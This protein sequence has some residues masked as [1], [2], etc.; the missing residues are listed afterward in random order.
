M[1][2]KVTRAQELLDRIAASVNMSEA[3]KNWLVATLD[4]MHDGPILCTG[5]PDN[6]DSPSVLQVIKQTYPV[7]KPNFNTGGAPDSDTWGFHARLDDYLIPD[8]AY[9]QRANRPGEISHPWQQ[10]EGDLLLQDLASVSVNSQER[11]YL[12]GGMTVVA[13]DQTQPAA[14][15]APSASDTVTVPLFGVVTPY[16]NLLLVQA[17]PDPSNFLRGKAR[18]VGAA[19]EI[20]NTTPDLYKS[21]AVLAYEQPCSRENVIAYQVKKAVPGDPTP[22]TTTGILNAAWDVLPPM[23]PAEAMILPGS[24]EWDAK[25]GSYSIQTMTDVD[26]PCTFPNS[27]LSLWTANELT[28][29]VVVNTAINSPDPT[30]PTN[31]FFFVPRTGTATLDHDHLATN[32]NRKT[33]YNKKGVIYTGLT[34]QSTFTLKVNWI[35]ERIISSQD[36]SLSTLAKPSPPVDHTA[37]A[38]YSEIVSKIPVGVQ[39]KDNGL[40]DWFLGVVDEIAEVVHTV[41]RPVMAAVDMYRTNRKK[42]NEKQKTVA[43]TGAGYNNDPSYGSPMNVDMGDAARKRSP[44]ARKRQREARKARK[45]SM[46]QDMAMSGGA[47]QKATKKKLSTK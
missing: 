36:Q 16:E 6:E 11:V 31:S 42:K 20:V 25:A 30:P 17:G 13:F 29:P 3:G 12:F 5:Y 47:P 44:E 23:S 7:V 10:V 18:L 2:T 46:A 27:E 32:I 14:S 33:P 39:F 37:L 4:P 24:Q 22:V 1:T 26:N 19:F 43:A 15:V 40:G 21:G 9:G 8:S 41:G 38:L 28:I 34:P 45:R 35:I